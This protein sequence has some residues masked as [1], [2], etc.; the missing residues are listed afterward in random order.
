MTNTPIQDAVSNVVLKTLRHQAMTRAPQIRTPA[1]RALLGKQTS[2]KETCLKRKKFVSSK[3]CI[4]ED[5]E[6]I[7]PVKDCPNTSEEKKRPLFKYH[8]KKKRNLSA[9]KN[10]QKGH[11]SWDIYFGDNFKCVPL[12]DYGADHSVISRS[13]IRRIHKAPHKQL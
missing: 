11:G 12:G 5:C 7:H 9:L 3:P 2:R 6:G 13:F 1:T 10:D 4:N 8:E